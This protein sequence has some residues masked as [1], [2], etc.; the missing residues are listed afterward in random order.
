[1]VLQI[2]KLIK[3]EPMNH[4]LFLEIG[5]EEIPAGFIPEALS[6]LASALEREL[7]NN[8]I[9]FTSIRTMGTPRRLVGIAEGL[10]EKQDTLIT[11]KIGPARNHAFDQK[12]NP[13]KAAIGF[14]H[15]QGVD[16]SQLET[17]RNEKGEYL[18][19]HKKEEGRATREILAE[20]LPGIITSLPFRKSMRWGN[21]AIS[22]ARPIHWITALYDGKVVPFQLGEIA[23]GEK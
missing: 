5:T 17:I 20:F 16:L 8:R 10:A 23:S 4:E 11:E 14:A 13:T 6:A 19:V 7:K 15:S 2:A 9:G 12:G 18:C 1:M 3:K 22:F 21:S